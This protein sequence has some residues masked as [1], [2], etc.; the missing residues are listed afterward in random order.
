M[1]ITQQVSAFDENIV[2]LHF[3]GDLNATDCLSTSSIFQEIIDSKRYFIMA[4]MEN[5]T[6]ISSPFLGELMGCKLRL[7]EKGGN[8]VIVGLSYDQ[9]EKL[10]M[11]GADHIFKFYPDT[12]TAYNQFQ[13]DYND[14]V[15][16]LQLTVPPKMH[17]VPAMRRLISGVARQK[18]YSSKDAF[19][20]ETIVD[21]IANNAIEHGDGSQDGIDLELRIGKTKVEVLIR[22]KTSTDKVRNLE[23]AINQ[24]QQA[25]I[26]PDSTRGRGLALVKLI[27]NAMNVTFDNNGTYVKITKNRGDS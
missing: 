16:T 13:W 19:R 24:G 1:K 4:M 25:A 8:L 14:G 7:V 6:F 9:R 3:D 22:N 5:V 18:G 15:Q 17:I 2:L 12:H 21:E 27:S 23:A 11:M 26:Q 20:I 10:I